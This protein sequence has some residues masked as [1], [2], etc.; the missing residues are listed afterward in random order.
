MFN[1]ELFYSLCEKYDVEL[2]DKYDKPMIKEEDGTLRPLVDV[3]DNVDELIL[4]LRDR[5]I[6]EL[7]ERLTNFFSEHG[8]EVWN[9]VSA[10]DFIND[11]ICEIVEKMKNE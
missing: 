1:K 10:A 2:S 4:Q 3:E 6:D 5:T 11:N 7:A 9:H 8:K